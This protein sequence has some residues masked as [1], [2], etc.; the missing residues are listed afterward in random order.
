MAWFRRRPKLAPQTLRLLAAAGL[1]A[2]PE[3]DDDAS[4]TDVLFAVAEVGSTRLEPVLDEAERMLG[5]EADYLA[6]IRFL[7]WLQ[8]LLTHGLDGFVDAEHVLDCLGPDGSVAWRMILDFWARVVE[9]LAR[10]GFEE[11]PDR[12][13][14]HAV[15]EPELRRLLLPIHRT[16]APGVCLGLVEVVAYEMA[17]GIGMPGYPAFR[18]LVAS[19]V[20]DEPKG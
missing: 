17:T 20:D 13:D 7:E 8:N 12:V 14:V 16:V 11:L 6:A 5:S 2:R 1:S 10:V 15:T 19:A 18:S 3:A 9:V 4:V